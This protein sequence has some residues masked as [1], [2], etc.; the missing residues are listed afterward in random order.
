V[1]SGRRARRSSSLDDRDRW[2]DTHAFLMGAARV[3]AP[4]NWGGGFW[5]AC[6]LAMNHECSW[7]AVCDSLGVCAVLSSNSVCASA[8]L[9]PPHLNLFTESAGSCTV[10]QRNLVGLSLSDSSGSNE[11]ILFATTPSRVLKSVGR[12]AHWTVWQYIVTLSRS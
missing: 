1:V 8:E 3:R 9:P 10:G 12:T 7:T 2:L 6:M 5:H 11:S 4:S